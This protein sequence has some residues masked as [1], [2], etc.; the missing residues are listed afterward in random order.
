MFQYGGKEILINEKDVY[1]FIQENSELFSNVEYQEIHP[2]D[3]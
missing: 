3:K 2:N 1:Q